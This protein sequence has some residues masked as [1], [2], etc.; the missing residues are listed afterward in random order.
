MEHICPMDVINVWSE[1]FKC[2]R[3]QI[4]DFDEGRIIEMFQRKLMIRNLEIS[5]NNLSYI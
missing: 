3:E 2:E 5:K 1:S 4:K